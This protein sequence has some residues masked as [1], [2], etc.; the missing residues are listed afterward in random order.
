MIQEPTVA[1]Q[2]FIP[3]VAKGAGENQA[4]FATILLHVILDVQVRA[5]PKIR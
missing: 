2:R 4:P 3:V 1:T 5:Y